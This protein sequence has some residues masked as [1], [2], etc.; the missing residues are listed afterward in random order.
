M[1]GYDPY[2][3]HHMVTITEVIDIVNSCSFSYNFVFKFEI[4]LSC[5]FELA[6][7]RV[8]WIFFGRIKTPLVDL[9]FI[10]SKFH[11]MIPSWCEPPSGDSHSH[12]RDNAECQDMALT[13]HVSN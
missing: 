9:A 6:I 5:P 2:T 7:W 10:F 1:I 4:D 8:Q 11:I 13:R 12:K 3:I